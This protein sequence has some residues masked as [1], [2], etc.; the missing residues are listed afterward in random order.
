MI[1]I[2]HNFDPEQ[3]EWLWAKYVNGGN[4]TQHCF[5]CLKGTQ[6]KKF[7]KAYNP[8]MV[9]QSVIVMDEKPVGEYD[10]IYFCGV[11]KKGFDHNVHLVVRHEQGT[12]SEWKFENWHAEI[13]NGTVE[14]LPCAGELKPDYFSEP[15]NDHYYTCRNF[16]WMVGQY[17]P[18]ALDLDKQLITCVKDSDGNYDT[19]QRIPISLDEW[20]II[21]RD[22]AEND[23]DSWN[24]LREFHKAKGH[25]AYVRDVAVSRKSSRP[26][27]IKKL[28]AL[29]LLI[30]GRN[31]KFRVVRR[32]NPRS[33]CWWPVFFNMKFEE[34]TKET[35]Y[36]LRHDLVVVMDEMT[37][38]KRSGT[39]ASKES[40]GTVGYPTFYFF[41]MGLNVGD[42][43]TFTEDPSITAVV[44]TNRKV[45]C[46]GKETY[47]TPLTNELRGKNSRMGKYW[48][49]NG[50][51]IDDLYYETYFPN[52]KTFAEYQAEEEE[53][54]KNNSNPEI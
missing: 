48:I 43:L 35:I 14:I 54:R 42:V 13:E 44:A 40:K 10:A 18:E 49:I 29:G 23:V 9:N 27:I 31:G 50:K 19:D 32:L 4:I 6:S 20:R 51:T 21:L 37:K 25:T 22:I 38:T 16:L 17:Y 36:T 7:S 15:Y 30:A 28:D 8:D 1:T 41:E 34:S 45:I 12:N 3:F 2:R 11:S 46:N 53:R 26:V 47:L 5:I 52:G 24:L 33:E 39:S